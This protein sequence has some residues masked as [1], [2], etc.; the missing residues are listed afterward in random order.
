VKEVDKEFNLC[1][2]LLSFNIGGDKMEKVFLGTRVSK[3][4]IEDLKKFCK[5]HGIKINYLVSEAIQEKLEEL[6]EDEEDI[7]TFQERENEPVLSE[8]E[9]YKRIKKRGL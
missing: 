5:E 7:A 1:Y 4:V 6:K 3:S 8:K 9:F 2:H